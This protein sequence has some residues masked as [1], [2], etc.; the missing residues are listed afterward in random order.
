MR[1]LGS[2]TEYLQISNWPGRGEEI[3]QNKRAE[4]HSVYVTGRGDW[5]DGCL[6]GFM[7]TAP[8]EGI[9]GDAG[10]LLQ[11]QNQSGPNLTPVFTKHYV[12]PFPSSPSSRGR[13]ARLGIKQLLS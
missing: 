8:G 1:H 11:S 3:Q 13:H 12:S 4:V 10:R 5:E 2:V 9:R 7:G 6:G